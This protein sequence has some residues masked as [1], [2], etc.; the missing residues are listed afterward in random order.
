MQSQF[1]RNATTVKIKEGDCISIC[2]ELYQEVF[3]TGGGE[4]QKIA[5]HGDS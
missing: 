4:I 3:I 2:L 1:S 5:L